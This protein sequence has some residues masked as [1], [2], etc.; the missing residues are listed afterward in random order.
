[1]GI[2]LLPKSSFIM[3]TFSDPQHIHQ[4]IF[5]LGINKENGHLCYVKDKPPPP[6]YELGIIL[7]NTDPYFS[8]ILITFRPLGYDDKINEKMWWW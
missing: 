2:I 8:C 7:P 1:M 6:L 5:I 4:G 3:V